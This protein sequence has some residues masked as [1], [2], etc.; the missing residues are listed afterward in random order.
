M[1]SDIIFTGN[2]M[3]GPEVRFFSECI[4]GE[5]K[6]VPKEFGSLLN[7]SSSFDLHNFMSYYNLSQTLHRTAVEKGTPIIPFRVIRFTQT[8]F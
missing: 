1:C 3:Q 4:G 5:A 2:K 6:Y 8:V 7:Q